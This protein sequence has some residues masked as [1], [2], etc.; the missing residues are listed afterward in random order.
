MANNDNGSS[1]SFG[2]ILGGIIGVLVGILIAPRSGSE[3][4]TDL[5]DRSE[6][7]RSRAEEMAARVRERVGPT[8]ESAKDRMAPA[9]E[10]LR[11]RV[12]PAMDTV[13]EKVTPVVEQVSSRVGGGR[14]ADTDDQ[15]ESPSVD[16]V[17]ETEE[18][19]ESSQI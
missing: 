18:K 1:F 5:A 12:T 4:R 17:E 7:W 11:S 2:F 19:S 10:T 9:V 14:Q 15:A 13:R 16:G 3:T 8:V 6:A